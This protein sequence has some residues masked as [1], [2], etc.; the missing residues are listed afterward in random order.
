MTRLKFL[1]QQF[2]SMKKVILFLF[3]FIFFSPAIAEDKMKLGLNVYNMKML[4]NKFYLRFTNG[5]TFNYYMMFYTV[6]IKASFKY[7]PLTWREEDQ[8]SN[9]NMM[10]HFKEWLIALKDYLFNLLSSKYKAPRAIA[11]RSEHFRA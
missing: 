3:I 2:F 10:T 5:L 11:L 7:F 9:L 4:E 8:I 6:G 1:E